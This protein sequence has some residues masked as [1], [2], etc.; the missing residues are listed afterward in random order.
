MSAATRDVLEA[1]L[2]VVD[3]VQARTVHTTKIQ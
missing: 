3:T 1:W 2:P